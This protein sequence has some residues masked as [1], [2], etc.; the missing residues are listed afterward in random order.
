MIG[1]VV[2]YT[3][4]SGPRDINDCGVVEH[5]EY[6]HPGL[7]RLL[8]S[9]AYGELIDRFHSAVTV[10]GPKRTAQLVRNRAARDRKTKG[11]R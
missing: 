11:R 8:I 10:I 2:E 3:D 6:A 9:T 5:V 4:A 1:K 7:W